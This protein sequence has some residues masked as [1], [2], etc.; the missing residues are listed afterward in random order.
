MLLL[1]HYDKN[2]TENED[3]IEQEVRLDLGFTPSKGTRIRLRMIGFNNNNRGGQI[4]VRFPDLHPGY[5]DDTILDEGIGQ[6]MNGIAFATQQGGFL[7]DGKNV[8]TN[9]GYGTFFSSSD[10]KVMDLDLGEMDTQ[11]D[12]FRIIVNGRRGVENNASLNN[13]S[14]V[15][16][17]HHNSIAT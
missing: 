15:L 13:F 14:A 3:F 4:Y 8:A 10:T 7:N 16:E 2:D 5:K 11:K 12:F 6:T 17:M 9:D 1:F